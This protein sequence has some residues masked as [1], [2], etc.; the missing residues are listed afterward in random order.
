MKIN[1]KNIDINELVEE[2]DIDKNI[3]KK[4]K[5]GLV[6]R[7]SHIEILKRYKI[8]YESHTTLNSLIFEIEEIINTTSDP[9]ELEWLSDELAEINYYNYTNK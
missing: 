8:D 4:R 1:G 2:V 3:L 5:N 9:E 6:L 7:D